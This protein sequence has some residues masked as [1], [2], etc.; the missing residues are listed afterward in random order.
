MKSSDTILVTVQSPD[1]VVWQ[2]QALLISSANSEGDFDI[3]PDHARFM[4]LISGTPLVVNEVDG[5][6]RSFTFD[7]AV[8]VFQ[9]NN[10]KIYVHT[11]T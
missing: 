8:L 7:N 5:S 10:A 11:V 2:G 1:A 3:M 9:D 6:N 4:T